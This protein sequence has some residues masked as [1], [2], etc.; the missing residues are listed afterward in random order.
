MQT[1]VESNPNAV[2]F[3][4]PI[5]LVAFWCTISFLNGRIGGWAA[6]ANR[7][8]LTFPFPGQTWSWKSA[9]MRW[10]ANYN[11]CLTIGAD[12]TGLFLS[13]LFFYRVGHPP[14]FLPWSE[15]SI[16]RRRR[17][18]FFKYVEF[19]LGREEQIPFLIRENLADQIRA[20]AASNWPAEAVSH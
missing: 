2:L 11:Q 12:P 17:I 16:P 6:L 19:R 3:V 13:V 8:R 5:F 4:F 9:R 15:I 18:L 10:G 14:L 7:F 20:A 1:H